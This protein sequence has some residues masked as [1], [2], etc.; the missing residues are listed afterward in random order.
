MV[1]VT[2]LLFSIF[3]VLTALASMVY[4]RRRVLSNAWDGV[5]LGLL[6]LAS[7][8]FLGW[9]VVKYMI[10]SPVP[11]RWSLLGVVVAGLLL[12]LVSRF[13]LR[14]PFFQTRRETD[15]GTNP[16]SGAHARA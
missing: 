6:P 4:Y 9:L 10:G 13:V 15:P 7:A 5:I 12:M 1:N 16:V 8:V 3:Y 14:S 2:G 11:Q